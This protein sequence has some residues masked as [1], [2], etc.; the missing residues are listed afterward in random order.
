[1]PSQNPSQVSRTALQHGSSNQTRLYL[2]NH[3]THASSLGSASTM[4]S[5]N[6]SKMSTTFRTKCFG[7]YACETHDV[8]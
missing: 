3:R 5:G 2:L 7:D 4:K 1:M 8:R 6:K